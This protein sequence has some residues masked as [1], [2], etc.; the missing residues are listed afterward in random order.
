M[1]EAHLQELNRIVSAYLDL[2]ENNAKRQQ[3]ILMEDW[4]YFLDGFLQLSSYPI[5]THKGKV[6][7][8]EAKSRV[9]V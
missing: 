7:Q 4:S 8:L 9:R 5:L 3:L 6:S 1:N 2:A